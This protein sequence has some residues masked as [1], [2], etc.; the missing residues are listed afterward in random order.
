MTNTPPGCELVP[1]GPT[2]DPD[3]HVSAL[4]VKILDDETYA[5]FYPHTNSFGNRSKAARIAQELANK[6]R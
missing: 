3:S 2:E 1:G 4:L 6:E 5:F